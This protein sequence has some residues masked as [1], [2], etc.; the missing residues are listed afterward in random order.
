MAIE[1]RAM[2]RLVQQARNG[3]LPCANDDDGQGVE[4]QVRGDGRYRGGADPEDGNT[5]L[6]KAPVVIT[7]IK[8]LDSTLLVPLSCGFANSLFI[9]P[10]KF[11]VDL[12][13]RRG[14]LYRSHS[15][16]PKSIYVRSPGLVS[17]TLGTRPS[18]DGRAHL[19]INPCVLA[20]PS[21]R[22]GCACSGGS[23]RAGCAPALSR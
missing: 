4:P 7:T 21:S 10:L 9:L 16:A 5:Y 19:A 20:H 18:S 22:D 23:R 14:A 12:L 1:K 2:G 17:L 8:A 13:C 11:F 15:L 6:E 3:A